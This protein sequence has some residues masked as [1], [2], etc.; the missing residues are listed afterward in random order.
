MKI[1]LCFFG[2]IR[3]LQDG[4]IEYSQN[5]LNKYDIDIFAHI[6]ND[7]NIDTFT[8]LYNPVSHIFE[9]QISFDMSRYP[10]AYGIELQ[11][12]SAYERAFNSISQLYSFSTVCKLRSDYETKQGIKYDL[13]IKSRV[14]TCFKSF[15][16][17]LMD[18][19]LDQYHV[20]SDPAGFIYNDVLAIASPK[21]MDIVATRYDKLTDWYNSG[22]CNFI[23]EYIT[24]K[25]LNEN[26]I[27]INRVNGLHC[28]LY[29]NK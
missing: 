11:H 10:D 8:K 6:W 22:D 12:S 23:P 5:L 15:D 21:I 26:D 18:L 24:N 9:D 20:P 13:C 19:T 16:I 2:Q 27:M 3:D 29:R 4:F 1:A 14:D 28:D 17:N 25:I 7:S